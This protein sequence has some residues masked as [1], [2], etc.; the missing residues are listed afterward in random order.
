MQNISSSTQTAQLSR[1][2]ALFTLTALRADELVE[3]LLAI[4]ESKFFAWRNVT[5]SVNKNVAVFNVALAV[6]FTRVIDVSSGI[7]QR[8]AIYRPFVVRFEEE[9]CF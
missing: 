7:I 4:I 1:R 2:R 3:I 5:E 8:R 9:A 6:R